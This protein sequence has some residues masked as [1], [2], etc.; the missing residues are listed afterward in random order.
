MSK[1]RVEAFSDGVFAVA[2]T[3]L[4]FNITIDKAGPGGLGAALLAAWPKY[5][6]YVAS[7]LTIGVMWINHHSLF[8]RIARMNRPLIFLNL[9]LLMAIVFLPF[10]T[11]VLGSNIQVA[12]DA[13]TAASLYGLNASVIAVLF[14]GVWTYALTHPDLLAP[15]VDREEAMR[16]WPRFSIGLVAYLACIPLG[17]ISPMAVVIVCAALGVYYLFERLPDFT[18][19]P[20]AGARRQP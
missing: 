2:A 9:L 20:A 13:N 7:F 6:A 16:S 14:S 19:Q 3:L 11:A 12:G 5:A 10:P 15:G 1:G 17:Q 4:I 18:R 8:E